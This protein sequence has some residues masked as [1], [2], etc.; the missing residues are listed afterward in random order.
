VDY[1]TWG[2]LQNGA[3]VDT[4]DALQDLTPRG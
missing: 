1:P 3:A 2:E 4:L